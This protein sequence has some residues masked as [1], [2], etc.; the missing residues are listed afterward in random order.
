MFIVAIRVQV[1]R[2][3]SILH[4]LPALHF[5]IV[6]FEHF[7][8]MSDSLMRKSVLNLRSYLFVGWTVAKIGI[9][10]LSN[11]NVHKVIRFK[12]IIT[13]FYYSN[14]LQ[15][16]G[17]KNGKINKIIITVLVQKEYPTSVFES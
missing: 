4:L 8:F 10:L 3:T 7:V 15:L 2:N 12:Q 9:S 11:N 14:K 13:K 5:R 16:L 1:G 17:K 6:V